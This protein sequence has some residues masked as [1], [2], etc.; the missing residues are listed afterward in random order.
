MDIEH[1]ERCEKH[2]ELLAIA[3]E[4][5]KKDNAKSV[6]IVKPIHTFPKKRGKKRRK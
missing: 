3:A 4:A 5:L 2:A 6:K 1:L